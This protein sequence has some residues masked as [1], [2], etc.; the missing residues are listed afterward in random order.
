M[1]PNIV[2]I[3]NKKSDVNDNLYPWIFQKLFDTQKDTTQ[4]AGLLRM[5]QYETQMISFHEFCVHDYS[6]WLKMDSQDMSFD[7]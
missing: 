4:L 3:K 7:Q 2:T 5:L 1:T 6:V